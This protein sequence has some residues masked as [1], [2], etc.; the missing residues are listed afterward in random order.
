MYIYICMYMI[1]VLVKQEFPGVSH[2]PVEDPS[3][4]WRPKVVLHPPRWQVTCWVSRGSTG[5]KGWSQETTSYIGGIWWYTQSS[6]VY[7]LTLL[8]ILIFESRCPFFFRLCWSQTQNPFEV[9]IR[10][11]RQAILGNAAANVIQLVLTH[12]AALIYVFLVQPCANP[13][14]PSISHAPLVMVSI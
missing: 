1:C 9:P 14:I 2:A 10:L 7:F 8:P 11:A 5:S 13:S 4:K 12:P 6:A 3:W